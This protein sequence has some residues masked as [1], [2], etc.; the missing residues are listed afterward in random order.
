M[1]SPQAVEKIK[2]LADEVSRREGCQLYD[3]E[4]S[5]NPKS[6]IL[7][8]YIEAE[9]ESVSVE[10]CANVSRGLSLMLDVE[11]LIP[12][13]G[14]EL[15]V[16][17]PGVERNL[18]EAWHF[19]RAVGQEVK[20]VTFDPVEGLKGEV[21]SLSGELLTAD[22]EALTVRYAES[23]ARVPYKN[24]KRAQTVFGF[25]KNEKKR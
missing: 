10:Q 9:K 2:S 5:G 25:K 12:G 18:R 21:K 4:F 15:E 3:V 16:S 6:R 17:S 8:V 14:Y 23:E 7:R 11:D 19:Q 13:G 22:Q 20:V 24:V 1:L